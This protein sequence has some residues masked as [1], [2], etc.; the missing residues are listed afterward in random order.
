[1]DPDSPLVTFAEARRFQLRLG[2]SLTPAERLQDLEDMI[3]FNETVEK[4]NPHVR[5]IAERL[6]EEQAKH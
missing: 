1:M 5:R 6:R 2:L 3:A 4:Y